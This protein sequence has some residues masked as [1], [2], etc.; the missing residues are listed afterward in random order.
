MRGPTCSVE[1]QLNAQVVGHRDDEGVVTAA[2]DVS[3]PAANVAERRRLRGRGKP[4]GPKTYDFRRPT[5][6]PRE[7]VRALQMVFEAFAREWTSVL[8]SYVRSVAHVN[9][10]SVEQLTYDEYMSTLTNPTLMYLLNLEPLS[11][12]G[13]LE[14]SIVNAM[15]SLDHLLGGPGSSDQPTRHL[16]DVEL[17]LMRGLMDRVLSELSASFAPLFAMDVRIR[18]I[19]YNPQFAQAAAPADMVVVAS[20]DLRVGSD[21]GPA[22]VSLPFSSVHPLL[23]AALTQDTSN[24][25][26]RMTRKRAATLVRARMHDVP[27][28]VSVQLRPTIVTPEEL[29]GLAVGDVLTLNHR[30]AEPFSVR[31]ADLTFAYAVPGSEGRRL[32]CL[33]VDPPLPT[34]EQR[35]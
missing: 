11:G 32:A 8:T 21:E 18:G 9:L 19:E 7:Q 15:V 20:F 16:T 26:E 6:M 28:D 14:L 34:K 23:E 1:P 13:V 3:L 10:V 33:V 5:Q 31:A 17:V 22:T 35:S 25:R 27:V 2:P 29:V 4:T 24:E 30:V 12:L